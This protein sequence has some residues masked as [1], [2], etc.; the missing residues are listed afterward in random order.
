MVEVII[1]NANHLSK[2]ESLHYSCEVPIWSCPKTYPKRGI[3]PLL[4][5][6][7]C[8]QKISCKWSTPHCW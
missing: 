3:L 8:F 4:E 2:S 6:Q 1:G 5:N 7:N